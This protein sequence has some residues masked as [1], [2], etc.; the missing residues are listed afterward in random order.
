MIPPTAS[1][2]ENDDP[3]RARFEQFVEESSFLWSLRSIAVDQPHY[4]RGEIAELE[5]R[6]QSSLDGLMSSIDSGWRACEAGLV[7]N[8]PG[9]LFTAAVTAFRSHEANKI[10]QV[11]VAGLTNDQTFAGL[12][13]A[14]GW[15]APELVVPWIE[16]LLTGKENSQKYLGVAACS[17]RRHDPGDLLVKILQRDD[18]LQHKALYVRA[19]RLVG[20]LRRQDLMPVLSKAVASDDPTI[21]FWAAWSSILLGNRTAVNYLQHHLLQ[22]GPHQQRAI[23]IVFRVLPVE[24]A[25]QWITS[26]SNEAAQYRAVIAATAVLGDPHA[27]NWLIQQMRTPISARIAGEAFATITGIDLVKSALTTARP[28]D[29]KA[30]PNDDPDDEN[31]AIDEDENLPWPH[32]EKIALLWQQ[33]GRNFIIGQRY[34]MGQPITSPWLLKQMQE[35]NQRQRHAAAL[36]LAL[37]DPTHRLYNTHA[38]AT[39]WSEEAG[40][41]DQGF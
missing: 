13:S 25:R 34:F 10:R 30:V 24:Q 29:F 20:E 21:S 41:R 32:A 5:T 27:V 4:N 38:R 8:S 9:E 16:K 35:A 18:C 14:L 15:L 33:L 7:L 1:M 2:L 3:F 31:I 22:P 11:V 40:S 28:T 36:E 37:T 12:V 26:I 6:I 23:Q 17:V 19:L 39:G